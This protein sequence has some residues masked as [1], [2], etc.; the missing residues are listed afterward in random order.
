M[1]VGG[2]THDGVAGLVAG[3]GCLS[4]IVLSPDLDVDHRTSSE[5]VFWRMGCGPGFLF[6]VWWYPYGLAFKHRSVW[7][8]LPGV[9][10]AIRVLYAVAVPGGVALWLGWRPGVVFWWY[11][12]WW[13]VGLCAS[14]VGHWVLDGM[15][16]R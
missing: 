8:H 5:Q 4:G 13:F 7:S 6:Q 15:P 16:V 2:W 3:V 11:F 14:D 10:T 12:W 1:G 9:G